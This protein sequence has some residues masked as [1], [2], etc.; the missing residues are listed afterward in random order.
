MFSNLAFKIQRVTICRGKV[1][2]IITDTLEH[3][4]DCLAYL[5]QLKNKD[6]FRFCAIPQIMAIA[7]LAECYNNRKIFT[8]VLKIRKGLAARMIQDC[9]NMKSVKKWFATFAS[10]ILNSVESDDPNAQRTIDLC[11]SLGGKKSL[12]PNKTLFAMNVLAA[13]LGAV[14]SNRVYSSSR[15]RKQ[16]MPKLTDTMQVAE[17]GVLFVVVIYLLGFGGV[18]VAANLLNN[19]REFQRGEKLQTGIKAKKFLKKTT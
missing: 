10:K 15:E 17:L 8:G 4:D 3:T 13:I 12:V 9:D 16:F 7:T 5:D 2:H 18:A 11:L 14:L 19:N 6:V 1:N